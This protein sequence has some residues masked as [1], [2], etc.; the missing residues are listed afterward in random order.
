MIRVKHKHRDTDKCTHTHIHTH[1]HQVPLETTIA[2]A[3]FDRSNA[4][5]HEKDEVKRKVPKET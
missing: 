2:H 1:T 4:E 5:A 3:S